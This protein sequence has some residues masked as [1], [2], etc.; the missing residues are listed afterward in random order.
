MARYLVTGGA[1]F[2]GSNIV[3][4]LVRRGETV[5][6]I[7]NFSTG[8]SENLAEFDGA[9][10]LFEADIREITAVNRAMKGVDFVM[11]EAALASVQRSIDDPVATN[12]VNVTGTLNLLEAARAESVKRFVFASSS[13]VY[14]DSEDLPKR[15]SMPTNPKSPYALTKLTGEWYVRI[16]SQV[17]GL[18]TV[19]LR[20]FNIFGAKQDPY[21]DYSAVIPLFIKSLLEGTTPTIFGDGEQS[22]DF[23]YIDNVIQANILA[24]APNVPSGK[25][26]NVAC[27]DRFTLNHLFDMLKKIIGAESDVAFAKTRIGDVKH[28]M[29]AIDE[30]MND[31]GY[32]VGVDFEDGLNR[33]VE[34]YRTVKFAGGSSSG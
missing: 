5:R 6:V 24:C 22:R 26:Y 27:G 15:E 10:E 32:T 29:A 30:V 16:F 14:G 23:T 7:D 4:E 25:V 34:W 28:S 21:S 31:L 20:Y 13:S 12:E 11:H 19:C 3:G 33:T 1:G 9:I 17:Y 8:K 2:V 18:P